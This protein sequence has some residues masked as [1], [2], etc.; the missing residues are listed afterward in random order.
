MIPSLW[1][2]N[3]TFISH[4]RD[5]GIPKENPT[6]HLSYFSRFQHLLIV[7][8]TVVIW[9]RR[10]LYWPLL[11]RQ[12]LPLHLTC[13]IISALRN[14]PSSP[15]D[16]CRWFREGSHGGRVVLARDIMLPRRWPHC[17]PWPSSAAQLCWR[18][19]GLDPR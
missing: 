10:P 8:V 13:V 17:V 12:S 2:T 19:C 11:S 15:H 14:A 16:T 5:R 9:V 1:R 3:S 18:I 6:S 7:T 4:L